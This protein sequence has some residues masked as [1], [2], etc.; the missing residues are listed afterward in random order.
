MSYHLACEV[1]KNIPRDVSSSIAVFV[2]ISCCE[3]ALEL[4]RPLAASAKP[5][6]KIKMATYHH[7]HS[8]ITL[9][10]IV[11]NSCNQ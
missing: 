4:A 1:V 8:Y 10:A 5:R 2:A 7:I 11:E 3:L 6:K 9:D